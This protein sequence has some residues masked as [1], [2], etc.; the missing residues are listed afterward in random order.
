M[1]EFKLIN[2]LIR[3]KNI[4]IVLFEVLGLINA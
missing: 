1:V 3:K 2:I 4:K